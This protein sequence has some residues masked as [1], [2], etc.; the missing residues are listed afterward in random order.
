MSLVL[1][2]GSIVGAGG[3]VFSFGVNITPTPTITPTITITPTST[4]NASVT[5]TPTITPTI[6]LTPSI[7]PTTGGAPSAPGSVQI[8]LQGQS[9]AGAALF[10]IPTQPNRQTIGWHQT[11]TPTSFN[12]YRYEMVGGAPTLSAGFPVNVTAAAS[13]SAYSSYVTGQGSNPVQSSVNYAWVDTAA[14]NVVGAVAGPHMAISSLSWSGNTVTV[15]TATPIGDISLVYVTIS[16]VTPSG[17]N[18]TFVGTVT[19]TSTFT[20]PL[21]SNPGTASV[22]GIWVSDSYV[23][24]PNGL[25]GT[26]TFGSG[27]TSITVNSVSQGKIT[28]GDG[29]GGPGIAR[30]TTFTSGSLG[31]TGTY[32]ISQPTLS[33]QTGSAIGTVF[34]PNTAYLYKVSAVTGGVE[35]ALS[36]YNIIIYFANGKQIMNA[37]AFG[38]V[39]TWGA[40]SPLTTPLGYS[41]A[42]NVVLNPTNTTGTG[43][44]SGNSG[45]GWNI[46]ING[47]NYFN[48]AMLAPSGQTGSTFFFTTELAGDAVAQA[49][50]NGSSGFSGTPLPPATWVN[51][52]FTL[53][54][55]V[56][57]TTTQAQQDAWYKF[58]LTTH[59]TSNN[60]AGGTENYYLEAWWSYD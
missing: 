10:S 3:G 30:G 38:S 2:N 53:P 4:I 7:T 24:P 12:I 43:L 49:S 15:N 8:I 26:A 17:Y 22:P 55:I 29:V 50:V 20:Y 6:T 16:G 59:Q 23:L 35:S 47:M 33:A 46:G 60:W 54:S 27:A 39:P 58:I 40:T 18:G 28:S 44:F 56:N 9:T 13:A 19:G 1:Y 25:I 11:T 45:V 48:F 14:N 5:P 37:G 52:K 57:F 42:A 32:T 31:T 36:A 21:A 51:L 41:V 34:L